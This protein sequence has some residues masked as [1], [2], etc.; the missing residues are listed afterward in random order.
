MYIAGSRIRE[1][2]STLTDTGEDFATAEAKLEE[3]FTHQKNK[4][5]EIFKF[6]QMKQQPDGSLDS[7][8]TRLRK[9][10][11]SYEFHEIELEIEQQIAV[12]GISSTISRKS[13]RNPDYYLKDMLVD[14]RRKEVS[15][16]QAK[17]IAGNFKE[18]TMDKVS[19]PDKP[20][21]KKCFNCGGQFPHTNTCPAECCIQRYNQTFRKQNKISRSTQLIGM[22]TRESKQ[23][24]RRVTESDADSEDTSLSEEDMFLLNCSRKGKDNPEVN[25]T[26]QK[27]N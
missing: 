21:L 2:I 5:Y 24:A 17:D 10:A 18:E 4:R 27:K 14:G 26:I 15:L 9:A 20:E 19:T 16:F 11:T 13:L 1:I 23:P 3:Y 6:R 8:H 7:F 12:G 22:Q 25:I